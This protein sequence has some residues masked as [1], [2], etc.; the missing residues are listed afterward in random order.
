MSFAP[1]AQFAYAVAR[2][3]KLSNNTQRPQT[4]T[5]ELLSG[6]KAMVGRRIKSERPDELKELTKEAISAGL[7]SGQSRDCEDLT[8]SEQKL[9]RAYGRVVLANFDK[10]V[11]SDRLEV[12]LGTAVSRGS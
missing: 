3:G 6:D 12:D 5:C 8:R 4:Q 7:I 1:C 9:V 11:T 10:R 2:A